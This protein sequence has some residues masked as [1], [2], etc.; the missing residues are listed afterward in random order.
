MI[1]QT[2]IVKCMKFDREKMVLFFLGLVVYLLSAGIAYATFS[3]FRP[4]IG[5]QSA[6]TPKASGKFVVPAKKYANL[7]KTEECPINGAMYSQPERALWEKRRPLGIMIENSSSARPQSGLS[8]ADVVYEAVAEGGISRFLAVFYCQDSDIVGPVRSA[9]TYYLDW[10]SEYANFPLYVHVGGANQPGPADA[11]GQ[12]G[13]YGWEAYNDLNQF[14]IGFPTF[15]RDYERLGPNTP[16]EHTVYSAA[17]KLWDFAAAKRKLTNVSIDDQTGKQVSWNADFTKWLF[18]DDAPVESR[19]TKFSA[20]FDLSGIQASYAGDYTIR[21]VY[22]HDSNSYLRF[23]GGKPHSD[24]N[25]NQQLLFKNI[26]LIFTT[27]GVAD[28]G[29]SE[30]GHGS[31]MLYGTKGSGRAKFLIDGK[32]IDGNW[33]KATRTGRTKFTDNMGA[34]IKF[35]RGQI[36]IEVLPIGQSLQIE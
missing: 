10:I 36:W 23:N 15:W 20:Q 13:Q 18:K 14:S 35:N 4:G 5:T 28:D 33:A 6:T 29:Y 19:P 1:V 22:D 26:V 30:D 31:H 11:L 16:T 2:C 17:A 34:Q 24:L 3:F 21:W 9:R 7:P 27:L 12:I 8:S 25:N 32:V